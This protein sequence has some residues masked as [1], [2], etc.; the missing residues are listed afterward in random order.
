MTYACLLGTNVRREVF[1]FMSVLQCFGTG[2]RMVL[3]V[4][5]LSI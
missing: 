5:R 3:Q 1:P 4:M 2:T